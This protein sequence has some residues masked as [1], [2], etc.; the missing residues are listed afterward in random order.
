[1]TCQIGAEPALKKEIS[2]EHP[3]LRFAYSRPGFVTFKSV[4]PELLIHPKYEIRSVFARSYGMSLGKVKG[5]NPVEQVLALAKELVDRMALKKKEKDGLEGEPKKLLRL[6]VWERD[7]YPKGEEA[8]GYLD[9]QLSDQTYADLLAA[10]RQGLFHFNSGSAATAQSPEK[11]DLVLDVIILEEPVQGNSGEAGLQADW[12]VGC[13]IHSP[14]HSPA[15]GGKPRIVLPDA[16][17]SRAYLKLEEAIRW[18]Q[19]PIAPG[20]TAV[21]IGS[22]PGGASFAL[23]ERG[24]HVVGIDPGEMAPQVLHHAN[25]S[26]IQRPVGTV[27]REELPDQVEWLL[28]DMNVEPRI[29]VYAVD[30]LVSRMNSC[31]LGVFLTIKLNQ[32]SFADQIPDWMAHVKAMGMS[33][34]RAIQLSHNRQEILIYGITLQGLK[35]SSI[36]RPDAPGASRTPESQRPKIIKK[37]I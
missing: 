19:A 34:V 25:F 2:R 6:H 30:R 24:L 14:S 37:S 21:E 13:H 1:M 18:S 29:S 28:L 12:W 26:H 32:W 20:D 10:D 11:E 31:L 16:S 17:P 4:D 5:T 7:R 8:L 35:R 3:E 36:Y 9:H 27:L 22:A 15:P 23:L 33:R